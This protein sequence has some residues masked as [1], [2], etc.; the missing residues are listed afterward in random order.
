MRNCS[1]TAEEGVSFAVF[2]DDMARQTRMRQ[3]DREQRTR[4]DAQNATQQVDA[5]NTTAHGR[6]HKRAGGN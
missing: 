6:E 4:R 1:S 2:D 3:Q 5:Q